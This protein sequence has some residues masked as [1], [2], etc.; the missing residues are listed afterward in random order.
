MI[1]CSSSAR[2]FYLYVPV[3]V[4]VFMVVMKHHDQM[5]VKKGRVYFAYSS[6]LLHQAKNLEARINAETMEGCG[7]L[8]C[9]QFQMVSPWTIIAGNIDTDRSGWRWTVQAKSLHPG[10]RQSK[11][12]EWVWCEL[13][14]LEAY[15]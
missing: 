1:G 4:R 5:Q 6:T 13:S 10:S 3:L 14:N 7:S 2:D 9:L 11:Q 15:E 12:S 8:T